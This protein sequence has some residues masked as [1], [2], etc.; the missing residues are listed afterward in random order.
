[1]GH[2]S[3][4][5]GAVPESERL[6]RQIFALFQEREK[7]KLLEL[8]HPEVEVVLETTRPGEVLAGRDAVA[9]FV[10]GVAGRLYE[11]QAFEYRPLDDNR[12]V[13]EGRLRSLDDDRILRDDPMIWAFEFLDGLLRRRE[14]FESI[15][16]ASPGGPGRGMPRP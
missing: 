12:I 6:A 5:G 14:P 15:L 10:D 9:E 2:G 1:M 4:T 8:I 13:I 7:E 3:D 16:A 11:T